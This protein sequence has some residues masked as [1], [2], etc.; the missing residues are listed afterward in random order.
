MLTSRST[1]ESSSIWAVLKGIKW[2]KTSIIRHKICN[3][4]YSHQWTVHLSLF[5]FITVNLKYNDNNSNNNI[6]FVKQRSISNLESQTQKGPE[7]IHDPTTMQILKNWEL[8]TKNRKLRTK[9]WDLRLENCENKELRNNNWEPRTENQV[10]SIV[11]SIVYSK[12]YSIVYSIHT[13]L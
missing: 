4:I 12:V 13:R 8:R 11:Y 10:H 3:V 6:R 2:L 7:L 9:N 1:L 5:C